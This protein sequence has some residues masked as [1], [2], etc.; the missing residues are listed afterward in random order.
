LNILQNNLR[1]TAKRFDKNPIV[2]QRVKRLP[3]IE[4]KLVRFPNMKLSQ[5]QDLGGCRAIL[6][7]VGAVKRTAL[8]YMTDSRI[9]HELATLDDYIDKPKSSGYRGVHLVYRYRSD[10]QQ[11]YN[12]LKIEIQI[13]S[14]FQHAWATAVETVG[15]FSGQALKSSLGSDKWQ[16]FFQLMGSVV[17]MREKSPLVPGTPEGERELIRELRYLAHELDV[18]TKLNGYSKVLGN[19]TERTTDEHYYLMELTPSQ[20]SLI[21]TGFPRQETEKA[22]KMYAEAEQR[23]KNIPGADAVLVSVDS[24]TALTKAYP[25]YFADTRLFVL[26]LGDALT[27]RQRPV[28]RVGDF[29]FGFN[30]GHGR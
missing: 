5:M 12:D 13:R 2:A 26:L 7:N 23:A 20:G 24:I 11:T 21:I 29:R 27:G 19:I 10:K 15:M 6:K 25:N 18:D 4:L 8:Y 1:K 30:R 17:A 16:R 3:S 28:T 14:Q 9:K 22:S